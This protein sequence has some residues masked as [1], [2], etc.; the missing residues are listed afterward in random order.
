VALKTLE[1]IVTGQASILS[2]NHVFFLSSAIFLFSLPLVFLVK[3][4][5][6]DEGKPNK[7]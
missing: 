4:A 6:R 5:R 3:D 1:N 7:T 2:Y